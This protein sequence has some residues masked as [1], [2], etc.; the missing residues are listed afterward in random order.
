MIPAWGKHLQHAVTLLL[1]NMTPYIYYDHNMPLCL[2]WP[3]HALM[4]T[5]T[6]TCPCLLWPQ[7]ALMPTMTTTCPYVYYDHNMPLCLLWPQHA[8]MS[9]MTTTCPYVYYDHNM[10]LCLLKF[11]M[12]NFFR[13]NQYSWWQNQYLWCELSKWAVYCSRVDVS[14]DR[15][16]H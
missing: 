3:Q 2:L 1:A 8:L 12:W 13:C 11:I 9:T 15:W 6:T 10:P 7:H 16:S 14:S 4:S 5:M